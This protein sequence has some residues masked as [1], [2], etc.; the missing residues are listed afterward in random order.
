M[1]VE[2]LNIFDSSYI[3]TWSQGL[4]VGVL[5]RAERKTTANKTNFPIRYIRVKYINKSTW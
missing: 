3:R 1:C 2:L 4:Q 5:S